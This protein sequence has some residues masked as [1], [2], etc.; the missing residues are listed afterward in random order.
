MRIYKIKNLASG[1]FWTGGSFI[2]PWA[3][4][5]KV[6]GEKRHARAA[7]TIHKMDGVSLVEFECKQ[8][9]ETKCSPT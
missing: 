8:V 6:Y 9:G 4:I 3:P 2:D 1:L 7:I 5:G